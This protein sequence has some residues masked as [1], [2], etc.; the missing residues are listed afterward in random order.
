MGGIRETGHRAEEV[1]VVNRDLATMAVDQSL[2][3]ADRKGKEATTVALFNVMLIKTIKTVQIKI[4]NLLQELPSPCP[5]NI[6][7]GLRVKFS[8]VVRPQEENPIKAG[9]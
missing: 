2:M 3:T 1:L 7:K 5:P 9:S 4:I 8:M 6:T